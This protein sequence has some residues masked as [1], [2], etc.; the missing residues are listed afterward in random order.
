MDIKIDTER[1]TIQ[2]ATTEGDD[3]YGLRVGSNGTAA[4]M[5]RKLVGHE[6]F[7]WLCSNGKP[8]VGTT[9][10]PSGSSR[11]VNPW[12]GPVLWEAAA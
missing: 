8:A 3:H 12:D 1:R 7:T 11:T 10:I 5:R 2:P 6:G 9:L 4:Q